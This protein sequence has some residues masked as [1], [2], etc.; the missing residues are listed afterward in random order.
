MATWCCSAAGSRCG[1][2]AHQARRAGLSACALGL[3]G[4]ERRVDVDQGDGGRGQ[5]L[6]DGEVVAVD[7]TRHGAVTLPQ[8]NV[9]ERL[10]DR[11]TKRWKAGRQSGAEMHC[12]G[13]EGRTEPRSTA[14][15]TRRKRRSTEVTQRR[16][17]G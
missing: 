10:P 5:P 9:G 16:E 13:G 7:D 6:E 15:Q 8:L 4:V 2:R 17:R 3:A 1:R 12:E 11:Y 14:V